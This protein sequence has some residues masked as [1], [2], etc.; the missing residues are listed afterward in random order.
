MI[1][2]FTHQ[3][4]E[5]EKKVN[6]QN[7]QIQEILEKPGEHS[8]ECDCKAKIVQLESEIN[9]HSK[10][11]KEMEARMSS[12]GV[13][14]FPDDDTAEMTD[15]SAF[16][17]DTKI[18]ESPLTVSPAWKAPGSR[19][20]TP[21]QI[22]DGYRS[23]QPSNNQDGN[24][25]KGFSAQEF[26]A[27]ATIVNSH[28]S[29]GAASN[30]KGPFAKICANFGANKTPWCFDNPKIKEPPAT[31]SKKSP[32]ASPGQGHNDV[33][34]TSIDDKTPSF[35]VDNITSIASENSHLKQQIL[36]YRQKVGWLFK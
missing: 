17:E 20:P 26:F 21:S 8:V 4:T 23:P 30:E 12:F 1:S 2:A 35:T 22:P 5:L 34:M 18:R 3:I 29:N 32:I 31:N 16:F 9:S 10:K 36:K 19:G 27:A 33:S 13:N 28:P 24:R 11:I 14:F 6:A 7:K 25:P 15:A